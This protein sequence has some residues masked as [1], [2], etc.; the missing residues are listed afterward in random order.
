MK[1]ISTYF[2]ILT[3]LFSFLVPNDASNIANIFLLTP[4]SFSE[5]AVSN[6]LFMIHFKVGVSMDTSKYITIYNENGTVFENIALNSSNVIDASPNRIIFNADADFI[7]GN[8]YYVQFATDVFS[9]GTSIDDNTTWTFTCGQQLTE[10]IK[11][12]EQTGDNHRL[13]I[14]LPESYNKTNDKNYPVVYITD[15]GFLNHGQYNEIADGAAK[16]EIDEYI[17]VGLG[18][19]KSKAL[20]DVRKLRIRDLS[21][22]PNKF[23]TFLKEDVITYMDKNYKTLP[24]ENTL[25]GN[26]LGGKFTTYTL[27]SYRDGENFPFKN[28]Y[29]VAQIVDFL[30]L[31]SNMANEI[32]NLP[33][34]FYLAIGGEDNADRIIAYNNLKDRLKSRN[35]PSF[36]FKYKLYEGMPHGEVSS[37]AAFHDAFR[38][39]IFTTD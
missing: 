29:S 8:S 26:S 19:P 6:E 31:E 1:K 4:S 10:I 36:K 16:G 39:L 18:Y 22:E 20:S 12:S 13:L 30:D 23:L 37:T 21:S 5:K 34:N 17:L 9:D 24:G 27:I 38:T 33:V 15:G 14:A 2:L 28:I 35:Y 25:I 7:L 3:L 32:D 11:H